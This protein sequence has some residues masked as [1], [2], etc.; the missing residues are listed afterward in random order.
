VV[1]RIWVICTIITVLALISSFSPQVKYFLIDPSFPG[2]LLK[3]GNT[4][5]VEFLNSL[6][7]NYSMRGITQPTDRGAAI[8]GL[9]RRLT[10]TLHCEGRYG[11]LERFL[12]RNL[13]WQRSGVEKMERIRYNNLKVPSWSWM[14][15]QGGIK[16]IDA[17]FADIY[18]NRGLGFDERRK[19]ALTGSLGKFWKC[20]ITQ[21]GPRY[22]VLDS[23]GIRNGW[24]QFDIEG[25]TDLDVQKCVVVGCEGFAIRSA[26]RFFVLV[27]R[28]TATNGEFERV[29]VGLVEASC[30]SRLGGDIRIV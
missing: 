11:I 8:F 5:A 14:A 22:I 19:D 26:I 23:R 18:W 12:H 2:R 4:H 7:E 29:G 15:Y 21:E 10:S 25:S 13:L 28:P 30:V 6:F 16:F 24:L 27:V 9:Q 20:T 17:S 1:R 3:A